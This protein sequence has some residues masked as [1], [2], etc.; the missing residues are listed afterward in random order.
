MNQKITS[1][2]L[3]QKDNITTIAKEKVASRFLT[4]VYSLHNPGVNHIFVDEQCNNY[5]NDNLECYD[6]FN[7]L[8]S[9]EAVKNEIYF[10]YRDPLK[11]YYSGIVQRLLSDYKYDN[12]SFNFSLNKLVD[13]YSINIYEFLYHLNTSNFSYITKNYREYL[14]DIIRDFI[15]WQIKLRVSE[16]AHTEPYLSILHGVSNKLNHHNLSFV[17]IDASQVDLESLF[18]K[19]HGNVFERGNSL[20]KYTLAKER[21]QNSNSSFYKI[22]DEVF[23]E[24]KNYIKF[25][26]EYLS[27]DNETYKLLESHERNLL[28]R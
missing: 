2:F 13:K 17:N 22:I 8:I 9:D 23:N 27:S 4:A 20:S 3:F 15:E 11:R 6:A 5:E 18:L 7:A 25:R 16:D 21:N 19:E 24:N 1:L 10:L 14:K 26:N 12:I 28:S